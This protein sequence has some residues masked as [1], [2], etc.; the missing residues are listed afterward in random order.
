MHW[1]KSI[2]NQWW[3]QWNQVN[4]NGISIRSKILVRS[5]CWSNYWIMSTL[6][7]LNSGKSS[8]EM[9][10]ELCSFDSTA[11]SWTKIGKNFSK[12]RHPL[13]SHDLQH[14]ITQMVIS[15]LY[16]LIYLQTICPS[17]NVI[18]SRRSRLPWNKKQFSEDNRYFMN[19]DQRVCALT[20]MK[21]DLVR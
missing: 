5:C 3:S 18:H 12:L 11:T 9:P 7:W 21:D 6:C 8:P 13:S 15:Q 16:L 4:L 19:L 14:L 10:L 2:W 17:L 20:H 1:F